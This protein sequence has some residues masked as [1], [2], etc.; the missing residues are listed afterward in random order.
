MAAS[1]QRATLPTRL[2][3]SDRAFS[4]TARVGAAFSKTVWR[5]IALAAFVAA[6]AMTAQTS[7]A[8]A[9]DCPNRP[10]ALGT[11]RTIVVDPAEYSRI[12]AMQ[13]QHTLPLDDKEV[14]LTFDDGPL[15]PYTGRILDTLDRHCVK[16]TFF[17]IGR[18]ARAYP[19]LARRIYNAGHTIGTHSENHPF[20]FAKLSPHQARQEIEQGIASTAAA[21]GDPAAVAAFFRIPGLSRSP[22][23]EA[24]LAERQIMVWSAD[25]PA[26]DWRRIGANAVV[27]RALERLE[28]KGKGVLLLHDIQ[29]AT[30][31][32]LPRL[33]EELKQRGYRIVHVTPSGQDRP[34]TPTT[35]EQWVMKKSRQASSKAVASRL[36]AV[37][38]KAALLPLHGLGV[39]W[40]KSLHP[41]I[42][43]RQAAGARQAVPWPP[44]TAVAVATSAQSLPAPSLQ[45]FGVPHPFGPKLAIRLSPS[46]HEK[47]ASPAGGQSNA[48]PV[49]SPV[50]LIEH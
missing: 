25:F 13:Y 47:V 38:P 3:R 6:T 16:A 42:A 37:L 48:A 10:D 22:E 19:E 20:N 29:P 18:M 33:I 8:L 23:S 17:L 41:A 7:S 4:P 5:S 14:V 9:S 1:S 30:V 2:A 27:A 50:T 46:G 24:I 32:A 15:P 26:D 11:S 31:L 44:V 21:L 45:S 39:D 28:L 49:A 34:K 12:G 43:G 36:P 40:L 35:P